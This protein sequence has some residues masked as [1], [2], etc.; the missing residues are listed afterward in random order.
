M[1]ETTKKRLLN[2][3][4][5]SDRLKY[6]LDIVELDNSKT[7]LDIGSWH[8][9]QSIEFSV[10]FPDSKI[11]A[12]EPVPDSYTDCLFKSQFYKNI[13]VFNLALTNF[14]GETSFFQVDPETSPDKNIGASSLLKFKEGLNGTMFNQ[15]WIQKEIKVKAQTLNNWANTNKINEI[16]IIWIDVQGAELQVFQG[17]D[18]ILKRTKVILTEVG[19]KPYYENHSIKNDIDKFLFEKGFSEISEAF[20]LNGCEYEGNAIYINKRI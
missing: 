10:I 11:Y 7:I 16:D 18:D 20:E 2:G 8:L 4:I 3:N 15:C 19:L 13:S 6:V 17:G 14:S 5:V 1:N 12:F 9:N